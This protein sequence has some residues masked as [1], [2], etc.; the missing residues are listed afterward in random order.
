[1]EAREPLQIEQ[2]AAAVVIACV[3]LA[4]LM[5]VLVSVLGLAGLLH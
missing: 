4:A 1:M 3:I 2:A 5:L